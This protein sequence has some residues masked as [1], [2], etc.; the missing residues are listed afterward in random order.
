[1][2]FSV[3]NPCYGDIENK[4]KVLIYKTTMCVLYD[5]IQDNGMQRNY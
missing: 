3:T 5:V 1:M 2:S 4:I